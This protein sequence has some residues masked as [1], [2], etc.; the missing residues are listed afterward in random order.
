LLDDGSV[1]PDFLRLLCPRRSTVH[2]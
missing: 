1:N 2:C